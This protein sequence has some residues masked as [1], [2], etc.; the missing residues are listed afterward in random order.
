MSG[1]ASCSDFG[2]AY[3]SNWDPAQQ[4]VCQTACQLP[5]RN[6]FCAWVPAQC[7]GST[8][9]GCRAASQP[10]SNACGDF[11][12]AWYANWNS[13]EQQKCSAA[14]S[15]PKTACSW[16][17]AQVVAGQF[18]GCALTGQA[19]CTNLGNATYSNWSSALGTAC[20][21][22][23][24]STC[25]AANPNDT[26]ADDAAL[27]AC[28]NK[29]GTVRLVP[30]NPGYLIASGVTV[31]SNTT[32]TSAAA[33]GRAKLLAASTLNSVMLQANNA[34][35]VSL[36]FLE[37]D[38][39]RPARSDANCKGYRIAGSIVNV[40]NVSSG[41]VTNNRF[42]RALCGSAFQFTGTMEIAHNL[43]DNNGAGTETSPPLGLEPWS[44]GLTLL[45]CHASNV[46]DNAFTDNTDI[47]IA[48]GGGIGCQLRNN[49]IVQ[50][51]RHAFSGLQLGN[52]IANGK[53]DYTNAQI[54][55]NRIVGNGRLSFG[56]GVSMMPWSSDR[57]SGGT[58]SGNSSSGAIVNLM[59]DGADGVTIS[60]HSF[61]APLGTPLCGGA[62]TNYT[63][64]DAANSKLITG[65]VA[66]SYGPAPACIP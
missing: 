23:C 5:N 8:F 42:T 52:F 13:G 18:T 26:L 60:N 7:T 34:S 2:G 47:G 10:T 25:P 11:G 9:T 14:C 50:L 22:A 58:L 12:G 6:D 57:V 39:N 32:V 20:Q 36:T 61:G 24:T 41:L 62:A 4:R 29:S 66:R 54:S 56:L 33:P 27:Q 46:H 51:N 30:G 53:G 1:Q 28:F 35:N 17:P 3:Y 65:W 21:Q 37:L 44:D 19:P 38:G 31:P 59:V 63:V 16:Q 64:D 49:T 43:F 55:G 45:D 15:N 48:A 40:G